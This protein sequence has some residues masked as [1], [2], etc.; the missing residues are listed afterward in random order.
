MLSEGICSQYMAQIKYM[1]AMDEAMVCAC[2]VMS[3]L[4]KPHQTHLIHEVFQSKLL[5]VLPLPT[6]GDLPYPGIKPMSLC[7]SCIGGVILYQLC[8]LEIYNDNDT[9]IQF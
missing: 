5:V 6:S 8:H 1:D 2:S 9:W 4:C 7:I 3:T